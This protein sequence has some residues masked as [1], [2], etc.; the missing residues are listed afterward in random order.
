ML[1]EPRIS[2]RTTLNWTAMLLTTNGPS[3]CSLTCS[4]GVCGDADTIDASS[5]NLACLYNPTDVVQSIGNKLLER[6]ISPKIIKDT[7][8]FV[9]KS[10]EPGDDALNAINKSIEVAKHSAPKG[11]QIIRDNLD[12]HINVRRMDNSIKSLH[13]LNLVAME[14]VVTG[15][16]LPDVTERTLD[17]V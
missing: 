14:D 7:C 1:T 9:A 12:L 17:V 8:A 6:Q 10:T 5:L 4:S 15:E 11:F 13:T 16:N 3:D 2:A